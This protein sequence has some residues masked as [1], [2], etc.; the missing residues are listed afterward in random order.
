MAS[1][2][3]DIICNFLLNHVISIVFYQDEYK[4]CH[5]IKNVLVY[6][7]IHET[8]H[9]RIRLYNYLC[10]K[11][12]RYVGWKRY[13]RVQY[14][15]CMRD[16][17]IRGRKTMRCNRV[18]NNECFDELYIILF[19]TGLSHHKSISD[20]WIIRRELENYKDSIRINYTYYGCRQY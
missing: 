8:T 4:K 13:S 2:I 3:Y 6:Y 10:T 18:C 11:H 1:W 5:T 17:Y 15:I 12:V 7:N 16:N 20:L 19:T 14:V 9:N